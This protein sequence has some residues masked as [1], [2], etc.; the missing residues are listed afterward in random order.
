[1]IQVTKRIVLL[2]A[3]S[4]FTEFVTLYRIIKEKMERYIFFFMRNKSAYKGIPMHVC[5]SCIKTPYSRGSTVGRLS[6]HLV[7]GEVENDGAKV[8]GHVGEP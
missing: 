3:I 2:I 7:L 6:F 5:S 1:L 8:D 4:V